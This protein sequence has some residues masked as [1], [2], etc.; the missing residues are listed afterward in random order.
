MG[1]AK[2]GSEC[3]ASRPTTGGRR[4]NIY[5]VYVLCITMLLSIIYVCVN[6]WMD[7]YEYEYICVD[8][9]I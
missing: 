6:A 1:V 2:L 4:N 5:D 3:A 7:E 9:Y 8:I